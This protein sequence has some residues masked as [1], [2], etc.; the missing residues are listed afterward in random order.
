MGTYAHEPSMTL[1]F[2]AEYQGEVIALDSIFVQNLTHGCDTMLYWPETNLA[3]DIATGFS[4]PIQSSGERFEI[5]QNI[6]NPFAEMTTVSVFLT[7]KGYVELT[8]SSITGQNIASYN[9]SLDAGIHRFSFYAGND[10][11]YLLTASFKGDT[12]SIKMI[13]NGSVQSG[14]VSLE[15]SGTEKSYHVNKNI[16]KTG[17]FVFS[18]GDL[19]RFTGYATTPNLNIGNNEVEDTPEENNTYTFNIIEGIRCH[20]QTTVS[21]TD[22]NIYNTVL[23]GDQCWMNENLKATK[24]AGNV[25]ITRYCYQ[26]N[27]DWCDIYGGL[28]KWETIMNE[29]ESNNE[30]P[31]G[32]QGICPT[33]WHVPSAAEWE[34]LVDHLGGELIAG[35]KLKSIRTEPEDHPRWDLPNVGA[36]NEIGFNALPGG[37]RYHNNSSYYLGGMTYFFTTYDYFGFAY[38]RSITASSASIPESLE[39]KETATAVRCIKD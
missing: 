25:D 16:I 1:T 22:G 39:N 7:E 35:G 34:I 4:E 19:L 12:R 18:L 21:D 37:Y 8:V 23:I 32:V 38:K 11:F 9:N 30:V 36:T 5:N 2:D 20:G 29:A 15:Y 24:T 3:F 28:Y 6:P 33:G 27:P 14:A 26:N 13:N 31:S 17:G 10:R